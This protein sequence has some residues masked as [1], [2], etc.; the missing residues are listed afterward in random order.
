MR[1][2]QNKISEPLIVLNFQLPITGKH[3]KSRGAGRVR[4]DS[5]KIGDRSKKIHKEC[6]HCSRRGYFYHA[7][8]LAG[9]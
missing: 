2:Q 5:S 6:N 9:D 3:E 8:G 1:T 7:Q 4:Y